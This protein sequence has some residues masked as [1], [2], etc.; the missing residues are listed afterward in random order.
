VRDVQKLLFWQ[1]KIDKHFYLALTRQ[2][3][4]IN[5][6]LDSY[7]KR[8][9]YE[10]DLSNKV[11]AWIIECVYY[12][13]YNNEVGWNLKLQLCAYIIYLIHFKIVMV[14]L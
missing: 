2:S 1:K 8:S 13:V 3:N 12:T 14:F 11:D 5:Y 6:L 4:S 7:I 9:V 10:M